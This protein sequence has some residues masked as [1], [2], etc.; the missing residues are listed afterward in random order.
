MAAKLAVFISTAERPLLGSDLPG[1]YHLNPEYREFISSSGGL[2]LFCDDH[3]GLVCYHWQY[4]EIRLPQHCC[5]FL[6]NKCRYKRSH[7]EFLHDASVSSGAVC[8]SYGPACKSGHW[9]EVEKLAAAEASSQDAESIDSETECEHEADA[10][11]LSASQIRWAHD[12]IEVRFRNGRLLVDTL[13]E[14][15]SGDL[16][17]CALPKLSVWQ[18]GNVWFAVTGN[19][20]L[21]VL[22]ELARMTNRDVRVAVRRLSS[23]AANSAWFRRMFTTRTHG[24]SVCFVALKHHFPSMGFALASL[25]PSTAPSAQDLEIG[26]LLQGSPKDSRLNALEAWFSSF[27]ATSRI[28]AR[29]DLFSVSGSGLVAFASPVQGTFVSAPAGAKLPE[30]GQGSGEPAS[31]NFGPKSTSRSLVWKAKAAH[32]PK[33]D[34]MEDA[35]QDP[36]REPSPGS[37]TRSP[38]DCRSRDVNE[39][40]HKCEQSQGS[41]GKQPVLHKGEH[42]SVKKHSGMGC[43]IVS[44][45]DA[46]V[47]QR[48]LV[49]GPREVGG[50]KIDVAA[51]VDTATLREAPNDLFVAWGRQAE[52]STPLSAQDLARHFDARCEEVCK[53]QQAGMRAAA[54][55]AEEPVE[56]GE[57]SHGL[58]DRAAAAGA[59]SRCMSDSRKEALSL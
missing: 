26:H 29:P 10:L 25:E 49:K 51:H 23:G 48:I 53:E 9:Q 44:F 35:F 1:F 4:N 17:A 55:A 36:L 21:W 30:A 46:E 2:R 5:Y 50:V 58:V 47:R 19:R 56:E 27:S 15:L 12:S 40:Q 43:A 54:K 33:E 28:R 16:E 7:G 41:Q 59:S 37:G 31:E 45:E 24:E 8:C 14:L 20:R 22:R 42:V 6:R 52:R 18:E 32:P 13:K 57:S 3:P 39:E 38:Q 34:A 11:E